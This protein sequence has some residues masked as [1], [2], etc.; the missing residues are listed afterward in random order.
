MRRRRRRADLQSLPAFGI[1][2]RPSSG[3]PAVL[4][5][6]LERRR[7]PAG[8]RRLPRR[9]RATTWTPTSTSSTATATRPATSRSARSHWHEAEPPALA[10]RGLRALPAAQRGH[11]RWRSGPRRRRSAWPTPTRSTTPCPTPTGSRRTPTSSSACGGRGSL[12]LRE[13]LAAGSGDTYTQ[14]R[15]GQAFRPGDLPNGD[16]SSPSRPTRTTTPTV[17]PRRRL[18]QQRLA[19]QDHHRR[20]R[21][22]ATAGSTVGA[23]RHHRAR[24]DCADFFCS[25]PTTQRAT[26]SPTG[27]GPASYGVGAVSP[28]AC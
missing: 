7:Q 3:T 18:P 6:R 8:R 25:P 24:R 1:Q 5:H 2:R 4:R 19:A 17:E 20:Q 22:R 23:G 26:P 13:V 21:A 16:Y 11:D 28:C 14:Y 10:L 15:A 9:R 27:D 12:S